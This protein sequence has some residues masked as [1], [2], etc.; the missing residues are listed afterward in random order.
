M[1]LTCEAVATAALGPPVYRSGSELFWRCHQHEDKH[2]SL[3]INT[4][5]NCFL[6]GPCDAKGGPWALAAF[7]ARLDLNDKT[8][9]ITW[10]R[11]KGLL[12]GNGT[13]R[14]AT[15]CTSKQ[16]RV[17]EFY[18]SPGLRTVR[19]E[20]GRDGKPKEFIW[21]HREGGVWRSG[22]GGR[23]KPLYA[24]ALFRERD[25][26]GIVLG[27]E[28]E[29]KCDLA[30]E[31]GYPAFSYKNLTPAQCAGLAGLDVILWP[32][33]DAPGEKQCT[34]AVKI[35]HD[36]KQPRLIRLI[37]P[38][39][40][41]PESGDIV[42]AVRTLGWGRAEMD[43]L[44]GNA[45]TWE[46]TG[47][48]AG[49]AAAEIEPD[50]A[51]DTGNA[52]YF[53][54]RYGDR[55]RY[56]HRRSRW[57]VWDRHRWKPDADA[58]VRR[59]AKDAMR[60][61]FRDAAGIEDPDQ[62]SRAAKWAIASES[63]ARLDALVYLAQS[64]R[65][66]ADAGYAW[67]CDPYL[68]GVPNGVV[69]LRTGELRAGWQEDRITMQTNVPFDPSAVSPRWLR[70]LAEVFGTEELVGFMHRAVGY[71]LTGDT[72]EQCLF[73]AY[74]RGANGKGTF[75]N[76]LKLVLGDYGWNM[77]FSTV[78]TRDRASI[79]NDVAALYGRRFVVASETNDGARLNESR[80]KA[81]TGCD[82]VTARFLHG[83]FFEFQ[84]VAKFWLSVNHKPIIRD[85][86]H[87][88]WRRIRLIPFTK[89][90]PVNSS[91]AEELR[92]EA[93]GILAWAARGCLLWQQK[94]LAP[95][96][97]VT[98]ATEEYAKDSDPLA[99]FFEEACYLDSEA[100]TGASEVF[101]HYRRWCDDRAMNEKERLS[102]TM[103]GRK[104]AER[105]ERKH[106][107]NGAVYQGVATRPVMGFSQ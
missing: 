10:L 2:P 103:F 25:Q 107:R 32:D 52:E 69:D 63:R 101:K 53:T 66:I 21:E 23:E 79:P 39:A 76:T 60:Q 106:T 1:S 11:E 5:K 98:E 55:L 49:T 47:E 93:A 46:P 83:E 91:L 87:G 57:L 41:L 33:K 97:L 9:V 95:P 65:P 12:N 75:S 14:S 59:L 68:L 6:C 27:F 96:Q 85:D 80:I 104:A 8:T 88:F 36:S 42:D 4:R 77:P 15:T 99:A 81:L 58:E 24:N 90:F 51:T 105:F 67:D 34:G 56:D 40:E 74:G 94:G 3:Q 28:G 72:S 62:R 92:A 7:L 64:E 17:A 35:L 29:A 70:F 86:S 16:R 82:P 89:T 26:L 45:P 30:G 71:S 13:R 73:L 61:R 37:V 43:S 102:A 54:A 84:P 48:G 19:I 50:R 100:E 18:Y 78:E 22:D 31:L 38:P 44:V 20:P